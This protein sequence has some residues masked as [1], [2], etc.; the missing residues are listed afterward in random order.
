[1]IAGTKVREKRKHFPAPEDF[2]QFD[3][4]EFRKFTAAE[5]TLGIAAAIL[6]IICIIQAIQYS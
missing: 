3:Q 2:T 1:M 5:M 6:L 4:K